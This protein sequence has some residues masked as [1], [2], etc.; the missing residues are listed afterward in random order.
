MPRRY[1]DEFPDYDDEDPDYRQRL[2]DRLDRLR[3]EDEYWGDEPPVAP[4]DWRTRQHYRTEIKLMDQGYYWHLYR[5][6]LRVNGGLAETRDD[7]ARAA[8][9]AT[10]SHIASH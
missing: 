7:A 2:R 6:D 10:T 4:F 8:R 9:S 3:D 1:L 5:D